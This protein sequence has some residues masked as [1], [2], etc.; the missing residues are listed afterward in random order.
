MIYTPVVTMEEPPTIGMLEALINEIMDEAYAYELTEEFAQRIKE[1]AVE[2][3]V[4]CQIE[5]Q[6]DNV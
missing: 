2:N 4:N 5:E 1:W 3:G 6:E